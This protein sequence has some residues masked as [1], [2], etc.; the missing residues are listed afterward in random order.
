MPHPPQARCPSA[1]AALVGSKETEP[2]VYRSRLENR[3]L[4]LAFVAAGAVAVVPFVRL[5]GEL[6]FAAL[7]A[8]IIVVA[9]LVIVRALRRGVVVTRDGVVVRSLRRTR[10]VPWAAVEVHSSGSPGRWTKSSCR[11]A[12]LRVPGTR[13]Q[14]G[15]I[16]RTVDPNAPK[17]AYG[18]ASALPDRETFGPHHVVMLAAAALLAGQM[19]AASGSLDAATNRARALRDVSTTAVVVSSWIETNHADDDAKYSTHSRVSFVLRGRTVT[20]EIHRPGRMRLP[21]EAE[22]PIVY[23]AAHPRDADYADRPTRE[24]D[25]AEAMAL[26]YCGWLGSVAGLVGLL[27]AGGLQLRRRVAATEPS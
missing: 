10:T 13:A 25:D 12:G 1:P 6:S 26:V 11:V 8:A 3:A 7:V 27:V 2:S 9:A 20:T 22:L 17:G 4:A 14:W 16:R 19:V 23:D 24:L 21:I 15:A 18:W 5:A